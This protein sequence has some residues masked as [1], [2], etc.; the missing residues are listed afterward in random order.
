[1]KTL[2]RNHFDEFVNQQD[3]NIAVVN[4]APEFVDHGTL[5]NATRS[6]RR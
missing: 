6:A 4:F 5:G 1:V 3:L 2:V